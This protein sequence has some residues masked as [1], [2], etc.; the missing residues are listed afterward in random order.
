MTFIMQIIH[1]NRAF[2]LKTDTIKAFNTWINTF[3]AIGLEIKYEDEE[4]AKQQQVIK[5]ETEDVE[6]SANGTDLNKENN[7]NSNTNTNGNKN[8]NH[9]NYDEEDQRLLNESKRLEDL[10]RKD[11]NKILQSFQDIKQSIIRTDT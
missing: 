6:M 7:C 11:S 8:P 3:I 5:F 9:I 4:M 1:K 2:T 10:L